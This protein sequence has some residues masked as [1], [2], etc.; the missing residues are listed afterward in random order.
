VDPLLRV[1]S[2]AADAHN[3]SLKEKIIGAVYTKY[4][5]LPAPSLPASLRLSGT[6]PNEGCTL[7]TLPKQARNQAFLSGRKA[8]ICRAVRSFI[9][10]TSFSRF[11]IDRVL[12]GR[13]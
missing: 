1:A 5:T 11:R 8:R 6:P 10:W 4:L 12:I 7:V 3:E 13:A 2:T 9:L